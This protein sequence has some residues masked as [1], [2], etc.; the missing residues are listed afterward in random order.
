MTKEDSI[1]FVPAQGMSRGIF[2]AFAGMVL[3]LV[4]MLIIPI[5]GNA[6]VVEEVAKAL[7]VATLIVNSLYTLKKV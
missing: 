4:L 2:A 3:P 5:T 1:T 6:E 7:I